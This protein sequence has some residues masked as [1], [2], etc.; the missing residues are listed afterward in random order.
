MNDWLVSFFMMSV[1]GSKKPFGIPGKLLKNE[2]LK[3]PNYI[4][5]PSNQL[6]WNTSI[7][8]AL[9]KQRSNITKKIRY[10]A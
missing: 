10:N 1:L 6:L 3:R 2:L 9:E 5:E 4:N 7:I 8:N